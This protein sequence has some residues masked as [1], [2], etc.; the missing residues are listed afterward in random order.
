[1]INF[2]QKLHFIMNLPKNWK[3]TAVRASL[4]KLIYQ[5]VFPYLGI[6]LMGLGGSG[7]HLG[8]I[9]SIGMGISALY[10]LTGAFFIYNL[11]P[12]KVYI[13]SLCMVA[14]SYL[15]LG[16]A[17]NWIIA[18]IAMVLW[19]LGSTE[20]GLCCNVICSGSLQNRVRATSMGACESVAQ[21]IMSFIGPTIGAV[22][23]GFWGGLQINNIRFLCFIAFW[24]EIGCVAF[25][26]FNFTECPAFK[27]TSSIKVS[28]FHILK[29]NK[30]L[31]KFVAV[32]CLSSI[33]TG[34]ILPFI[35]V[36][37][38][39]IKNADPY[40]LSAMVTGSAIM[41]LVAG[42]PLGKFADTV[43]RKKI[44]CLLAPVYWI[45]NILLVIVSS[46][47]G[48]VVAGILQGVFPVSLVISAAMSFEQVSA[49]DIND[50]MAVQRCFRMLTG[51]VLTL[52]SGFIWD[53]LGA[54]WVFYLA[55]GIDAFVRIPLLLTIPETLKAEQNNLKRIQRSKSL[56]KAKH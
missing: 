38:K 23:I 20:A 46:P 14:I 47:A 45:S 56:C 48:L 55:I 12:K 10:G 30:K 8:L 16:I 50:W 21:G 51:A 28:P 37:A 29:Q 53:H 6:Y 25:I 2:S 9:N 5:M 54:R 43:G 31:W 19:W 13:T 27:G 41:S 4:D 7:T 39:D 33:P 15:F 22:L 44:L 1:M 26:K 18:L 3:V 42:L 49:K 24:G 11:G 32:S 35:Q 36:F 40:I 34:M 52:L 17:N